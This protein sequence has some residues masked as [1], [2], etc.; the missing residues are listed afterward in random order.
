MSMYSEGLWLADGGGNLADSDKILLSRVILRDF[1]EGED[2]VGDALGCMGK[3]CLARRGIGDRIGAGFT[4]LFRDTG[5]GMSSRVTSVPFSI[6]V[7][8]LRVRCIGI[9]TSSS[10]SLLITMAVELVAIL[11]PLRE[12]L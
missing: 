1:L 11:K 5:G 8:G 4:A 6:I 12:K 2:W 3:D 9:S 7:I 10:S